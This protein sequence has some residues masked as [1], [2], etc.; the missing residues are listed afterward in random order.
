MNVRNESADALED[1]RE[2]TKLIRCF[3]WMKK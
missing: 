3:P 2:E 1:G